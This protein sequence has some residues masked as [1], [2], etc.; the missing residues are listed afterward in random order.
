M[1]LSTACKL[2]IYTH[3][4]FI[5]IDKKFFGVYPKGIKNRIVKV[6]IIICYLFN[7]INMLNNQLLNHI[8]DINWSI[9]TIFAQ[10]ILYHQLLGNMLI[11]LN[12]TNHIQTWSAQC[13][14]D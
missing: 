7:R 4:R 11:E 5:D 8:M 6:D 12:T 14:L 2:R 3:C 9:K 10:N 1:T 13:G